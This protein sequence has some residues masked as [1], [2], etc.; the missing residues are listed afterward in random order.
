MTQAL[1]TSLKVLLV[2]APVLFVLGTAL[3]W[4]LAKK[5]FKGKE[6]LSLLILLPVALPPSVLGLYLLIAMG[7]PG[8]A[9][10]M[11]IL[12]SFPAVLIAPLFQ[13]LPI[14]VQSA[15]SG[16][17]SVP[18]ALEEAGRMLGDSEWKI[19]RRVTFPLS[20]KFLIAGLSLSSVRAL[21]DFGVT[22]MIAGNIPGKTQTLPLYIYS[23]MESLDFAKA[24]I[25]A[26]LL[27]AVGV[28]S[29]WVTR[30]MEG[31]GHEILV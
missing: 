23:Q 2:D 24:N 5:R 4:L 3:G 18:A 20:K 15:R 25:A 14:M 27:V 9:R 31:S 10:H 13:A 26:L 12:F 17:S 16:F 22:L 7:Q 6:V 1:F 11:H 28:I 21:G 29:L 8:W 30:K 19:F